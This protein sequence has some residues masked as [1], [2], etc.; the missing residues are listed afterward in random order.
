MKT[1]IK[2]KVTLASL[3]V[4]LGIIYG[5][6]GTSPLYTFKAIIG[7]RNISEILVLGGVSCIFWTLVLQTSV[8]YVWLT[9]K[10]DNQGEGGIFSLYSLVR[11]YGKKMVIP[12]MIGAAA[13]LADGIITP[14]V[15]VTSA[16]E[17]LGIIKGVEHVPV[18]PIV[19]AVISLIFFLQRFGTQNVGRAFGPIMMVWFTVL[20]V[21][22]VSQIVHYPSVIK[23]L[24][25]YYA[26]ELL[27]Q[28]PKGF[29]LLG[30][31]FL[32]TTGAEA[33]YSDLG[34]CG[35]ENIRITWGFVKVCLIVNYL[36]QA[37]WLLHQGSPL[38]E[39][40]N[41]FFEMMPSWFL[42]PGVIVS[43]L[44]AIVASQALISGSFTLIN[45]AINLNFWQRVA[46]KQP[47]ETKGQIYIPSVNNLLWIGCVLVV[48]YFQTSSRMEAAYGLA[49]TLAMMM[50][51][52]LLS[53]FL[54]YKLKWNKIFVFSLLLVFAI[55]EISFFIANLVKFQEGGYITVFVGGIFFMVMYVSYFGR[56][57]NN[58]YTKFT[59]LGKFANQIV[60]LSHDTEIPKY[61]THLIYLTKADRR[62]QIEEKIINSIFDKKPK[63]ADV[64]WF[65]HINRTNHPYTLDYEVSE[66][67]DDKV[68][69]IV[70]NIGFRIQPRTEL[71]FEKIID[72]LIANKELNLHLRNNGTTKYNPTIDF[73]FI[74]LEKFL[75]VENEFALKEGIILNSY[76]FLKR[77]GQKDEDA[78]GLDRNDVLV[79]HIPLVYQPIQVLNLE[80]KA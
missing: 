65:F 12:T 2:Q 74:L 21:L 58:R 14:A 11:R 1:D 63:R 67:V 78:F 13:L 35:R 57:I 64:Y 72:D 69:K 3:V 34:H 7:E 24:N 18:V 9:L 73:K 29:W 59:D 31:V 56:K 30:A 26:Y 33:L 49:I 27:S 16:I 32:C 80:R 61:T 77:F 76:F 25:P 28:Y 8:K 4:A 17:G 68:I 10:A 38:L 53:Y 70:L 55:I 20:L 50:T 5:D 42:I 39:G 22:G 19:I 41:P 62:D 60:D 15:S 23:A 46:I 52:F 75:S 37:S 54:I 40:R 48:L 44:A 51:T 71:Y 36:G 47:T 45:E 6:I 43:T 79:E 66:L